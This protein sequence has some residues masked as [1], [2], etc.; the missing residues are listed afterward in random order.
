M[1]IVLHLSAAVL[2]VVSATW[3]YRVNYATQEAMGRLDELRKQIA[4]EREAIAVLNAEWAYLNRPDRLA[5]LVAANAAE[6]GLAELTPEQFGEV[7]MVAFPPE[8]DPL[9][10]SDEGTPKPIPTGARP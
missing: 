5:A 10:A 1:R 7:T 2:V 9:V 6:L 8:P 4:H 3:A